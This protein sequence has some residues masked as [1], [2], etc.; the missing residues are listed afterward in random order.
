MAMK[1]GDLMDDLSKR[2][3]QLEPELKAS[4]EK[5]ALSILNAMV[6]ELRRG[7]PHSSSSSQDSS[8][9]FEKVANLYKTAPG[10]EGPAEN[11]GFNR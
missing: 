8:Q 9:A 3:N 7:Q 11:P 5:E 4:P 2:F 6:Q 10:M 1:P